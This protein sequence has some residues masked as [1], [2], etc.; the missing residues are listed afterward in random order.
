MTAQRVL[1][2]TGGGALRGLGHVRRCLSLAE[3]LHGAGVES[4][5]RVHGGAQVAA[6][7]RGLGFETEPSAGTDLA[8]AEATRQAAVT[9]GAGMI[10]AD[11]YDF[12][13][14][15]I[16]RLRTRGVRIAVLDDL[17]AAPLPVD[18]LING[19][20]GAERL[21]YRGATKYLLGA[22]YALLRP[23]FDAEPARGA[24]GN[25]RVLVT[26]GGSDPHHVTARFAACAGAAGAMQIDAVV[27]PLADVDERIAAGMTRESTPVTVH[28][29][30]A[31]YRELM[32]AADVAVS[33]GG[34]T[35]YELAACATPAVAVLT[36]DNQRANIE[37]L[38]GAGAVVAAGAVGDADLDERVTRM[39]A[40]LLSDSARRVAMGSAGRQAVDGQG[41]RRVAAAIRTMLEDGAC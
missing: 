2:R 39:V 41:A 12:E 37:G 10:I 38:S 15:Y 1:I 18:L 25:G 31:D 32:L 30:P 20:I 23:G 13:H 8:D 34:Q 26:A 40:D 35:L 3:A 29:D 5:F 24:P 6:L 9:L 36:A 16:E 21:P 11:S 22:R 17:N 33:G 27:G 4:S 7:I 14:G 28:R 19:A